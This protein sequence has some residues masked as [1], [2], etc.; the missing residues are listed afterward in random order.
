MKADDGHFEYRRIVYFVQIMTDFLCHIT[1]YDAYFVL[2]IFRERQK[3]LRGH[4]E[5]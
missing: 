4:P 3:S 2:Q 1:K 5:I